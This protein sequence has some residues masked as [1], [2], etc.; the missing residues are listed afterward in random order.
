MKRPARLLAVAGIFLAG[1]VLTDGCSGTATGS[2]I[3]FPI[4]FT[5]S[6]GQSARFSA[7]SLKVDAMT[8]LDLTSNGCLG[9]PRGCPD[10]VQLNVTQGTES[11]QLTLLVA[12]TQ[13]QRAQHID[14]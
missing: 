1:A 14:Q 5:L 3:E 9:G 6:E 2:S 7:I 13:D 10:R 4:E 8:V 11:R 12:H